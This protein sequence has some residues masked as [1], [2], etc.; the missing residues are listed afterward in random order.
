M[1]IRDRS[2]TC[3]RSYQAGHGEQEDHGPTD[4]RRC[5]LWKDGS[6]HPCGIQSRAGRKTGGIFSSDNDIGT[7]ALQYICVKNERF[8][9]KMCIRDRYFGRKFKKLFVYSHASVTNRLDFPT[10]MLPP[11]ASK[12]PPTEMVG[13]IRASKKIWETIEVVVVFPCVPAIAT[14]SE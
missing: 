6:C 9:G 8:S 2:G 13:S 4:L 14:E 11:I 12:I 3:H 10:R 1:C 5:R 7:T